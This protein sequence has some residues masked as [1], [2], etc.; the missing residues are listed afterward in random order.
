M[1]IGRRGD[2]KKGESGG[3]AI[4]GIAKTPEA[5]VFEGFRANSKSKPSGLKLGG[6][7]NGRKGKGRPKTKSSTRAASWRKASGRKA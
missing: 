1:A 6:K 5:V 3:K 7:G 2:G 4:E